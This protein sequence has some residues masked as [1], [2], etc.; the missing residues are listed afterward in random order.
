VHNDDPDCINDNVVA[1]RDMAETARRLF[2][3][4]EVVVAPLSLYY[5]RTPNPPAFLQ[6][7]VAPWLAATLIHAATGQITAVTLGTDVLA[8]LAR[9]GLGYTREL[10]E[11]FTR[12]AGAQVD[13][14]DT[15][16]SPGLH[17]AA[18][19]S[20]QHGRR[21]LVANPA[22]TARVLSFAGV[23]VP[24][25]AGRDAVTRDP[26]FVHGSEVQIPACSVVWFGR[27]RAH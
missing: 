22:E 24:S 20:P 19:T 10:L 8:A 13:L 9:T 1:V 16:T 18:L 23:G 5:P 6:Q 21:I 4:D 2:G 12:C 15:S 27:T 11:E 17:A 3:K 26:I 25:E 7:L 14:L